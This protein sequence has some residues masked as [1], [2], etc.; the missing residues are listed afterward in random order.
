[1]ARAEVQ[2]KPVEFLQVG[3]AP[4]TF[5]AKRALAIKGVEHD[6]FEEISERHVVIFPESFKHFQDSLFHANAGLHALDY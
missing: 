6:A 4:E 5:P 3:N 2:V 1:V